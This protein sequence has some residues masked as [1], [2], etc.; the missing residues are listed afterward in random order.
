MAEFRVRVEIRPITST[1]IRVLLC[2]ELLGNEHG[3][4]CLRVRVRVGVRWP[5]SRD[6]GWGLGSDKYSLSVRG[7]ITFGLDFRQTA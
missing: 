4:Q 2:L 3:D 5:L 6:W 1:R 7:T